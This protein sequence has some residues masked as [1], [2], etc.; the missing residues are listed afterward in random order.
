MPK[1]CSRLADPQVSIGVKGNA[2]H[3]F[4]PD[5]RLSVSK[6]AIDFRKIANQVVIRGVDAQ[7]YHIRGVAGS[8]T[9]C[10]C[11]N[12][13]NV[14]TEAALNNIASKR[15]SELQTSSAG[16]PVSVPITQGY[17]FN[18]GDFINLYQ[19]KYMLSGYFRM[20]QVVKKK[21]KVQM[22]LDK[23]RP[24]IS[25]VVAD[26]KR[27][28][29]KGIYLPGSGAWSLNL[30]GLV[31]L[32][33]LDEGVDAVAK[34]NAPI[35]EPQDG[36]IVNGHWESNAYVP[37][38]YQ[39]LQGD[40]YVDCGDSVTFSADAQFSVG[41]LFSPSSLSANPR[42][43]IHKDGQFSLSHVGVDGRLRF[44]FT[45][46]SNNIQTFD[47]EPGVVRVGGRHFAVIS[48]D[49]ANVKMYMNGHL[50]KSFAQTGAP[51]SSTNKVYLGSS[52]QGVLAHCMLWSR[53]LVDQEVLELY[54]FP[55]NR[56]VQSRGSQ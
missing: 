34:D 43:L 13:D 53:R 21:T 16:A 27:W 19:P 20:M 26:L 40:G 17:Y 5:L 44:T 38:K 23:I 18:A 33:R 15:L 24:D 28:E 22:Q 9:P 7:G 1:N 12:E 42:Y 56:V 51:H 48:Y 14:S 4:D 3:E 41:C 49:G 46:A 11:F 35:E 54:F 2:E 50:H 45:D 8:G 29:D 37:N 10:R 25:K 31:G 55:L 30:Q 36:T 52:F 6:R 47:S 39:A 32:Y